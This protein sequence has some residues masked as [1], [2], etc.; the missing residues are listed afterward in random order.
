MSKNKTITVE[1]TEIL[2]GVRP[3]EA[4][5]AGE[6]NPALPGGY[7]NYLS[8]AG[9]AAAID[10]ARN[11]TL[12]N[13]MSEELKAALGA[14][15]TTLQ[16]RFKNSQGGISKISAWTTDTA[17]T[18]FS[19]HAQHGNQK[20]IKLVCGLAAT[21]LDIIIND[22]FKR[23]YVSGSAQNW[24]AL[25]VESKAL[26]WE[27]SK[28]IKQYYEAQGRAAQ[29]YHYSNCYDG[30]NRSLFGLTA[31]QIREAEGLKHGLTRDVFSLRALGILTQYQRS[32]AHLVETKGMEPYTAIKA[33]HESGMIP[34]H[35]N[36]RA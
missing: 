19:Y 36:Y 10:N 7:I 9:M 22:A 6:K 5:S 14:D 12:Q 29:H 35:G 3:T 2:L 30:I 24:A 34:P 27:L 20:A 4:Y 26:F 21:S 1:R 16:C 15:F 13:R 25:R 17:T 31:K 28:A 32:A 33:I 8:G 23:E 11:T 18:Y